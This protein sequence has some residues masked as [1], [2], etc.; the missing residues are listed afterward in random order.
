MN[1]GQFTG[2]HGLCQP[3]FADALKNRLLR[4][5]GGGQD[6]VNARLAVTQQHKVS[7]STAGIDAEPEGE[8]HISK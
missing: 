5:S 1:H 4:R 2:C 6:L 3:H 7:K 8:R